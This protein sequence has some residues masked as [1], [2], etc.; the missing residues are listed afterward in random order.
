MGILASRVRAASRLLRPLAGS[1][2]LLAAFAALGVSVHVGLWRAADRALLLS[3]VAEAPCALVRAGHAV[4]HWLSAEFSVLYASGA[5]AVAA[6][7]RG[8]PAAWL[9][10]GLLATAPVELAAK[11]VV[12]QPP[13]RLLETLAPRDCGPEGYGLATVDLPHVFPS[14]SVTRLAY[15]T[16]LAV[17]AA[18]GPHRGARAARAAL[19]LAAAAAAGTRAVIA[20]HWPTDIVGGVLLGTAAAWLAARLSQCRPRSGASGTG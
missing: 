20:W 19:V 1:L 13:P 4:S 6:R 18:G 10:V 15:F 9:L 17:G 16:T 7:R 2:A 12:E 11:H 14:G 3:L 5:A 8:W